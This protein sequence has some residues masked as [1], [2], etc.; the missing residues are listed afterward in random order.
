MKNKTYLNKKRAA[1][2]KKALSAYFGCPL[3]ACER[4]FAVIDI[5][6]DLRHFC[7]S[8]GLDFDNLDRIASGHYSEEL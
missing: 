4:E 6:T 3:P 1:R 2:A 7:A 5:L 8:S